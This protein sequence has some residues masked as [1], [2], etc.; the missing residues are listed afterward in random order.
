MSLENSEKQEL[1]TNEPNKISLS[2]E[3]K[4]FIQMLRLAYPRVSRKTPSWV[5]K[6]VM[7]AYAKEYRYRILWRTI[8]LRII[9]YKEALFGTKG[10][11]EIVLV[12]TVILF[13]LGGIIYYQYTKPQNNTNIIANQETPKIKVNPTPTSTSTAT[14]SP[15][16]TIKADIAKKTEKLITNARKKINTSTK[17]GNNQTIVKKEQKKIQNRKIQESIDVNQ[18]VANSNSNTNPSITNVSKEDGLRGVIVD[19]GLLDIKE[20]Y[21]SSFGNSEKDKLLE[22]ALVEK[23]KNTDFEVLTT[24]QALAMNDYAK[25]VKKGNLIQI[26]R[27]TDNSL[28]WYKS[29]EGLEGSLQEIASSL[30]DSLLKD[31]KNHPKE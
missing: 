8:K 1:N 29:I 13:I 3:D 21:V 26:V 6:N 5:K 12:S 30:I 23:L 24:A 31:I 2:D 4:E 17:N 19:I 14:P 25:I 10:D 20:F 11:L 27:S 22:M 15:I 7:D 18:L 28:L 9:S 16:E